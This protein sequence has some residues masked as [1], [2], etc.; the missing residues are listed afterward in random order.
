LA[1]GKDGQ[2]ARLA[3]KLTGWRVDVTKPVEG[4]IFEERVEDSVE[5]H[6]NAYPRRE[7]SE[8][9]SG[10]HERDNGSSRRNNDR[11]DRGG[12]RHSHSGSGYGY[13]RD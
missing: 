10:R 8:R 9:T 11:R 1:I 6:G 2:N 3:A 5:S 4:E 12:S 13:E 7:R